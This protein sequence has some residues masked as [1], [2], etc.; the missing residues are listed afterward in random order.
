[1]AYLPLRYGTRRA[2]LFLARDRM[3]VKPLFFMLDHGRFLFASEIKT[4]MA[5]PGVKPQIDSEGIAELMLCGPGRTPGCGIFK[6]VQELKPAQYAWIVPGG[7]P[8]IHRYWKLTPKA[9]TE[10]FE[11]TAAHV[12]S[13][14]LDAI[15]ASWSVMYRLAPF[16]GWAGLQFDFLGCLRHAA[17]QRKHLTTFSVDYKDNSRYFRSGKFQPQSD[18]GLSRSC[19]GICQQKTRNVSTT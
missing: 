6:G 11:E 8:E 9:H 2:Q 14:V 10:S 19:S 16:V 18:T 7:Q 15:T 3:G 17:G 5:F 4:L 13:L 12:R 1:M